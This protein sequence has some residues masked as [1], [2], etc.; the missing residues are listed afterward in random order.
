MLIAV[1]RETH[2]GERRVELVPAAVA[3]L[4]KLGMKVA[5]EA[6]VGTGHLIL[7][8]QKASGQASVR[9]DSHLHPKLQE[10]GHR[11]GH[12]R[13]ATLARMSLAGNSDEHG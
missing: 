5:I 10:L 13:H 12:Q 3:K 6:N 11:S 9:F 7:G 1:P 8:V 4:L 2:L